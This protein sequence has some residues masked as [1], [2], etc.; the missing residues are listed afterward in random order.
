MK[1]M[2]LVLASLLVLPSFGQE[3]RS[4]AGGPPTL[5]ELV[6]FWKKVEIPNEQTLNRENPWPQRYQ[7][8]A[9]Y[10]NGK[11]YSMMAN[12]D[13]PF[14]AKELKE[15]FDTLPADKTPSYQL[16]GQFVTIDSKEIEGY[17]ELWGVNLFTKDVNDFLKKGYLIMTL[18][19][20]RGEIMYYRLLRRVE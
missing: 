13:S 12:E 15:I 11:V 6:G 9:F 18:D 14:T 3:G 20:G 19:D 1:T 4:E 5:S 16:N 8:F 17:R 10:A 7:W 2:L